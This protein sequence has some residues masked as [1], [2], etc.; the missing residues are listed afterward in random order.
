MF[1]VKRFFPPVEIPSKV[2]AR[3]VAQRTSI[4]NLLH[5]TLQGEGSWRR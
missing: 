3:L 1:D 2:R 4:I 5:A